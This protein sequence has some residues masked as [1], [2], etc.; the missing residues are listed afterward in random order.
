VFHHAA[1]E[2]FAIPL[3]A[4]AR[5]EMI[6][7][8]SLKRVGAREYITYRDR[9]VPLI[10]LDQHLPV[11]PI[12]SDLDEL[13]VIVPKQSGPPVGILASRVVDILD[14]TEP[15]QRER[16][17]RPGLLGTTLVDGHLTFVLDPSAWF[18]SANPA[19]NTA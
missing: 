19:R 14:L 17:P 13:F 11:G 3:S 6:P 9:G 2:L 12:P 7:A 18:D 1:N 16:T 5:L 4:V 15:V 8:S 10:R